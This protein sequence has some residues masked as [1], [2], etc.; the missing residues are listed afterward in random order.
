MRRKKLL[1]PSL[2]IKKTFSTIGEPHLSQGWGT[3]LAR[4]HQPS[5]VHCRS[6]TVFCSSAASFDWRSGHSADS[7]SSTRYEYLRKDTK[8]RSMKGKE[9]C[10]AEPDM[11][12]N[13][14][15][16]KTRSY[17]V[18]SAFFIIW[19]TAGRRFLFMRTVPTSPSFWHPA[20]A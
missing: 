1:V 3:S 20:P 17:R 2:D 4:T 6:N 5:S 18:T 10:W 11:L 12:S 19:K 13:M 16:E 9:P 8:Q 7:C 15:G 14:T